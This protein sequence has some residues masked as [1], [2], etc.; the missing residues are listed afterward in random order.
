MFMQESSVTR[1]F[2]KTAELV[3]RVAVLAGE[4]R[5]N[6]T[7]FLNRALNLTARLADSHV[8]GS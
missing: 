2:S 5:S 8:V 7:P 3:R 6:T 1:F 4:Q